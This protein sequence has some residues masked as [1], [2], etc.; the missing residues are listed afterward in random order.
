MCNGDPRRS[1]RFNCVLVTVL[2]STR[3]RPLRSATPLPCVNFPAV[4]A[5]FTR[6]ERQHYILLHASLRKFKVYCFTI[7][8]LIQNHVHHKKPRTLKSTTLPATAYF[9]CLITSRHLH[10]RLN[11]QAMATSC[12]RR[13]ACCP[14]AW[15]L[16]CSTKPRL[17]FWRLSP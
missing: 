11:A 17:Q 14:T 15:G 13:G 10:L 4:R 5:S 1:L 3:T 8:A 9:R 16:A 2:Q 12:K 6:N 7:K